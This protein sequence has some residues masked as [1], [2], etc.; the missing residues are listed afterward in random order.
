MT[1]LGRGRW[2]LAVGSALALAATT[3]SV[4]ASSAAA[5]TSSL[6]GAGCS[7]W[8]GGSRV[9]WNDPASGGTAAN[10]YLKTIQDQVANAKT[11]DTIKISAYLFDWT[12]TTGTLNSQPTLDLA[13][14]LKSDVDHGASVTILMDGNHY[15]DLAGKP[16]II[17]LLGAGRVVKCVN[18]N[19]ECLT[20]NL[21][22]DSVPIMHNKLVLSD[23][24]DAVNPGNRI[25]TVMVG[26]GN[27]NL[28]G[29]NKYVTMV[30]SRY[31]T[32]TP[33]GED[34]TIWN[35]WNNYWN[36]QKL[37]TNGH[38]GTPAFAQNVAFGKT[39]AYALPNL[40]LN[41]DPAGK[42]VNAVNNCGTVTHGTGTGTIDIMA[43]AMTYNRI[44]SDSML[45]LAIQTA[46]GKG[47]QIRVLITDPDSGLVL[48][49][50]DSYRGRGTNP[51]SNTIACE[52]DTSAAPATSHSKY[53]A[54]QADTTIPFNPD[55]VHTNRQLVFSG[56]MN[57]D[58]NGVAPA[59]DPWTQANADAVV[60]G[61]DRWQ[62]FEN[63][64]DYL[65]QFGRGAGCPAGS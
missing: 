36:A 15:D 12:D 14:T 11:G 2:L 17:S 63:Q 51:G 49:T 5:T 60:A 61:A 48:T 64:F 10:L 38:T 59:G 33:A 32:T 47:C 9:C 56:S 44:R 31:D 7:V 6:L 46:A 50:L 8:S 34:A 23:I 42:V 26:S 35:F 21:A 62:P 41:S 29:S 43:E 58:G 30:Q 25:K 16:N 54:V 65:W 53:I 40:N 39:S 28:N 4:T 22:G 20:Q 19:F 57:F 1:K 55:S 18:A 52:L 24:A 37:D 27:L 3:G 13:N 45:G